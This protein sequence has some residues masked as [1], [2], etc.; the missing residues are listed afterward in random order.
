M[1]DTIF[2]FPRNTSTT[3]SQVGGKGLSLIQGSQ[4]GL[5]VPPGFIL[6]VNFFLPWIQELQ[7]TNTWSN[8]LEH[9]KYDLEKSCTELKKL[10]VNLTLTKQQEQ[11]LTEALQKFS[12][13]TLFA[14]R[15][16]S[17]E[18]DLEG[19]SF[20]GGYETVLGVQRKTIAHA[21]KKAF[22]SCLDYRVTVYKKEHGFSIYKP[23][24]AVIVQEQIP[25]EIAG[26]GFSLNPV[27]NNFDEAVIN[28]NFGLGESVVSGLATPDT[29]VVDKITSQI[30][31][32]Q[33]GSKET[34]IT[35]QATGGTEKKKEKRHNE[36][37][38]TDQQIGA[39]TELIKNVEKLFTKPM[40]I[41]WAYA[42]DT[43]YL[44]Q[45]R[46]ITAFVPLSKDT[47]TLPGQKKRLYFDITTTA[48]GIDEPI[49]VIGVGAFRRLVKI[50]GGIVF[51]RDITKNI[52]TSI[53]WAADNGRLYANLSNFIT[54]FGKKRVA[55]TLTNID[56][57]AAK[58]V[59]TLSENEYRSSIHKFFLIPRGLLLRAPQILLLLASAKRNPEKIHERVQKDLQKFEKEAQLL[60]EKNL[61]LSTL[62]DELLRLMFRS[63]FSKT[64]PLTIAS[65]IT[66]SEMKKLAGESF[67]KEADILEL[68]LPNNVTVEMGLSLSRVASHLPKDITYDKLKK[69]LENQDLSSEFMHLWQKFL[70]R[71]GMRG[72]A[73]IDIAA[74]RYKED[75][76][77]LLDLMV[78]M[79][80]APEEE[81]AEVKF[82]KNVAVRRQAVET[83]YNHLLSQN[84]KKAK[85]F[86]DSY[87]FFETFGG[88][89]ETHKY[90][91]IFVVDILRQKI[92]Q[93]SKT[94]QNDGRLETVDQVFYLT[95]EDLDTANSDKTYNL[96]KIAKKN[97]SERKRFEHIHYPALIDSRGFIPQPSV[98]FREKGEVV[99]TP[100]SKGIVRGKI[101]V[102]HSPSEKPLEK[103]EILVARATDPG[104]TPLFVN[105]SAVILEIGGVLQ[106]GALVAREYGVPC[107]AGVKNATTLWKDGTFVEVDGSKGT[108]HL[109]TEN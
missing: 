8:Y 9:E 30:K 48:Q 99:G 98:A 17:P 72:P 63:V 84:A 78:T 20:A 108:I 87:R 22:A 51:G 25:S 11:E 57:I 2:V 96:I 71:Y 86:A 91:L 81:N 40:D 43:L 74:V 94:L 3:L 41:E 35:L 18:E 70:E 102:L 10:V 59:Q 58:A 76:S 64:V 21:I 68:A 107:V 36:Y 13:E 67:Q 106:H 60:A 23:K 37:S 66:L 83:I 39:I 6:S 80:N 31:N 54:L 44:L 79:Q 103:G 32:K 93:L 1:G 12:Q 104:W 45:A 50:V 7:Q 14:V 4:A 88:Y 100:I 15:S 55:Q 26:V 33:L 75:P 105:A 89:R 47:L 97:I 38:L 29:F 46:P 95:L 24:I 90:Y 49:S 52:N 101:K 65:R 16:S 5:P 28:S 27:T 19:A 85:K 82:E 69:N 56:S 109:I 73:E 53:A 34:S 62:W 77:L 61:P 92:L 42:K